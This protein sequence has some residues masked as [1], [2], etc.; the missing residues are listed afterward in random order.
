[1]TSRRIAKTLLLSGAIALVLAVVLAVR[2]WPWS[3]WRTWT[4]TL[5]GHPSV[6]LSI[7]AVLLAVSAYVA[8]QTARA[9]GVPAASPPTARLPWLLT[10]NGVTAAATLV[11]GIGIAAL[12]T[13]WFIAGDAPQAER[14]KLQ[15]EALKYGVGFFAAAGAVAAL[16]LAVRR[17]RLSEQAHELALEAQR[18]SERNH[19]LARE[20]Q[21]HT[22]TD[23]AER[24]VTDLYTKAVEQ[25]GHADAAVR[26]GGLYALERVAYNNP[27][28]RQTIVNVLCAYLRMPYTPPTANQTDTTA[29][30]DAAIPLI[31]LPLSSR[32]S[33]GPAGSKDA[34]QELQVRQTAQR[35][36][37]AHLTLP[38][39]ITADEAAC[40]APEPQQLFWPHLDI[41][42]TGATLVDWNLQRGHV[43]NAT[44]A[45][46]TF[47]GHTGFG[48]A[49]FTGDAAFHGATFTGEARFHG[50]TFTGE[51]WFHG[52]TFTGDARFDEATL[53]DHA[54]Y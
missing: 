20:A 23:A 31:A 38:A 21:D 19:Q 42:L 47:T 51:A 46:T 33:T 35:I 25:L 40:L 53:T 16:L 52:A 13:M 36:L 43:H 3:R 45:N 28:Q 54:R 12:A 22:R 7:V 17:Q 41:D 24:R 48:E 8:H 14:A 6:V 44:F 26:L 10:D 50:A 9:A 18:L 49:T 34:H 15:I 29:A 39:T 37:A 4:D 30:A 5:L 2:P 1:M 32:P 27:G 11:A